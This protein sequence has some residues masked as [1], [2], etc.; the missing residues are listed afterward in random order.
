MKKDN[1][2]KGPAPP[3]RGDPRPTTMGTGPPNE[4]VRGSTTCR[5]CARQ[6]IRSGAGPPQG[7]SVQKPPIPLEHLCKAGWGSGGGDRP[8]DRPEE[9]RG[10]LFNRRASTVR[11]QSVSVRGNP[12]QTLRT[13]PARGDPKRFGGRAP[14]SNDRRAQRSL[15]PW[16]V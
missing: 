3:N 12:T 5:L 15:G 10:R 6:E 9:A 8:A 14:P 2:P 4:P 1:L 16:W 13:S 7:P 11:K